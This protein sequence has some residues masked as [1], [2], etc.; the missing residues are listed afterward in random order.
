MKKRVVNVN[1]VA[2]LVELKRNDEPLEDFIKINCPEHYL[3]RWINH[4]LKHAGVHKE[5]R[6]FGKDLKVIISF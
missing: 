2:N 6:N 5:V 3:L 1:R 4:H